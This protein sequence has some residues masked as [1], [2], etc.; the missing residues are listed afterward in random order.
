M[1]FGGIETSRYKGRPTNLFYVRYG[2]APNSFFAYTD[3]ENEIDHNGVT[4]VPLTISRGKISVTGTMDKQAMEVRA[5]LSIPMAELF[6]VYPPSQV[7]NLIIYQGHLSDPD[8]QYLVAWAG[9]IISAKR[10][11]NEL[12][13]TCEPVATSMKRVGLRR[14]YQYSCMHALY[15]DHCKA[16]KAAATRSVVV[17]A[18]NSLEL[19]LPTDW[20]TDERRPKYLGGMVEWTNAMGDKEVRSILKVS[21]TRRILV[22]GYLRDLTAGMSIDVI[23]GCNRACYFNSNG[24]LSAETDCHTL[25]GNIHNFGGCPFIPKKNPIGFYNQYY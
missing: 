11:E 9:R 2:N 18:I 16:N 6:R 15:G 19:T 21:G 8:A 3:A 17:S 24:S 13:M 12:V 10:I 22:S 25:H 20:D 5:S 1:S 23:L 4:Y 7:V 14:H